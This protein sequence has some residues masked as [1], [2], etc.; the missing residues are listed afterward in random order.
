MR[1]EVNKLKVLLALIIFFQGFSIALLSHPLL[2][3]SPWLRIIGWLMM[4]GGVWYIYLLYH[5]RKLERER[6]L[7]QKLEKQQR[8]YSKLGRQH[9]MRSKIMQKTTKTPEV[10]EPAEESLLT[11]LM[12]GMVKKT[13][14][15]SQYT[16]PIIGALIIDADFPN[17]LFR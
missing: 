9:L 7:T 13:E 10:E 16:L 17:I 3:T 4:I 11:R 1:G 15:F 12:N 5:A 14:K 6:E 2:K 8:V